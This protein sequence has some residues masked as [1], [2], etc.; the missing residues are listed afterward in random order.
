MLQLDRFFTSWL[1]LDQFLIFLAWVGSIFKLL[2]AWVTSF[3]PFTKRLYPYHSFANCHMSRKLRWS[4]NQWTCVGEGRVG[5]CDFLLLWFPS[6]LLFQVPKIS[7]LHIEILKPRIAPSFCLRPSRRI[8]GARLS[9]ETRNPT[10]TEKCTYDTVLA[11][12]FRNTS[13]Y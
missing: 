6:V 3:P 11:I 12:T 10:D 4:L 5:I 7:L 2:S 9:C 8:R 1:E 13:N